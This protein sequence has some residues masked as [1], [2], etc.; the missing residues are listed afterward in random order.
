M[1]EIERVL[2]VAAGDARATELAGG[3]AVRRSAGVLVLS[4]G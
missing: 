1:A 4:V 3:R 2:A